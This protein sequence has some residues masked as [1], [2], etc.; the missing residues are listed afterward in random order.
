MEQQA[1]ATIPWHDCRTAV[2]ALEGPSFDTQIQPALFDLACVAF[3]AMR[4]QDWLN[5]PE[6]VHGRGSRECLCRLIA[7]AFVLSECNDRMQTKEKNENTP[8]YTDHRAN[9]VDLISWSLTVYS[10]GIADSG[11]RQISG[12]F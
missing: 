11:L 3:E 4:S 6:E 10:T 12:G 9:P 5:V 2:A 1:F 8:E 7:V